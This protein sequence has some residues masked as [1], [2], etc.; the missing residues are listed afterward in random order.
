M[1]KE[2]WYIC[3]MESYSAI[4]RNTFESVLRRWINLKPIIQTEV[5][6]KETDKYRILEINIII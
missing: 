4:E 1:D 6:Q 2:L 3:T 5:S